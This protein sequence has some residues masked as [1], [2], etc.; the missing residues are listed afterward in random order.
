MRLGIWTVLLLAGLADFGLAQT[1]EGGSPT[2]EEFVSESPARSF[3]VI[4]A[5][6]DQETSLRAQIQVMR[7]E[8]LPRRVVFVPHWKYVD[9][10]RILHLHVPSG[11]ASALF[12]HLPSGTVF[13]D[14]DR[15]LGK[16]WL[17]H[18]MAH[19]LGHLAINSAREDDAEKAAREYRKRLK[20]SRLKSP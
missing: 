1:R 14:G 9:T 16:A 12:T 17:G 8:V 10:A 13:V 19:E 11:Y 4:G 3:A 15:Y 2:G 20:K 6:P 5:T 7:P 18:W